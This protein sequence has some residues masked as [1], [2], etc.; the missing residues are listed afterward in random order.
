MKKIACT[1]ELSPGQS[2]T[3]KIDNV[4]IGLFNI[5]GTFYAIDDCCSHAGASLSEGKLSGNIVSCPWHHAQFDV[6]TGKVLS[7]PALFDLK[8]YPVTIRNNDIFV[9]L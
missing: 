4:E 1:E 2:K 9:E 3:V 5:E 6:T 8:I 7:K